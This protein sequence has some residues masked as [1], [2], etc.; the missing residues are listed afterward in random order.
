MDTPD[1]YDKS[2]LTLMRSRPG[3]QWHL[4]TELDQIPWQVFSDLYETPDETDWKAFVPRGPNNKETYLINTYNTKYNSLG[5]WTTWDING[6]DYSTQEKNWI[7]GDPVNKFAG[8]TAQSNYEF[9]GQ[10]VDTS[11]NLYHGFNFDKY[12][13]YNDAGILTS[14]SNRKLSSVN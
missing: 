4:A 8:L 12:T 2:D 10:D 11:T 5:K 6:I 1:N 9:N 13:A 3:F 7:S 14:K